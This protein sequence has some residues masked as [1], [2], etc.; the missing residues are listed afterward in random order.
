MII[1]EPIKVTKKMY[2]E[3]GENLAHAIVEF[4]IAMALAVGFYRMFAN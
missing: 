1:N 3:I 2:I 4:G